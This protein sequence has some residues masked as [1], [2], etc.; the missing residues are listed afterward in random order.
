MSRAERSL[1]EFQYAAFAHRR[2]RCDISHPDIHL[3]ALDL[4][5]V[6]LKKVRSLNGLL[7]AC[8]P[9]RPCLKNSCPQ[10]NKPEPTRMTLTGRSRT[11]P[12]VRRAVR[13]PAALHQL[14]LKHSLVT[15]M[16][17]VARP[18]S[19]ITMASNIAVRSGPRGSGWSQNFRQRQGG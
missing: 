10:A 4:V 18:L 8:G 5:Q 13:E 14:A 1:D 2:A 11:T 15:P 9:S 7:T 19:G 17:N 12:N 6:R 16:D 3:A